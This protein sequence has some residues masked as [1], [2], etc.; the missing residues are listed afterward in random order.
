MKKNSKKRSSS[1]KNIQS[2]QYPRWKRIVFFCVMLCIPAILFILIET[3]LMIFN[4]FPP[5]RLFIPTP[6]ESSE[7]FGINTSVGERYF[8]KRTFSP[9]PRKDLFLRQKP[10]NGY[11]LFVLGGSTAAGFPYGNSV[12]FARILNRRLSDTF[13]DKRIEVVNMAMTAINTYTLLDFMDDL[14]KQKPDALLIYAGH[15]EFYGALGAGSVESAGRHAWIVRLYLKMQRFRTFIM[16]RDAIGRLKKQSGPLTDDSDPMA[17]IM[18]RIVHDKT[19]SRSSRLYETTEQ[20]F[21]MNLHAILKKSNRAGVPV[22]ISELV[23][24]LKDQPPFIAKQDGRPTEAAETFVRARKLETEGRYTEAYNSYEKAKDLDLLRFR[25]PEDF[26]QIIHETASDYQ[27]PVIP[28]KSI[29]EAA[30]PHGLIG[31]SLMCDHLHPNKDGYFLMADAFYNALRQEKLI[32]TDWPADVK[33]SEF[34]MKHWGF[35]PLDSTYAALTV[36]HLKGGWPFRKTGPNRV[37]ELIRART[38]E[39]S[40]VLKIL[41]NGQTT[42]EMGH[43]EL[44]GK[45]ERTGDIERALAEYKALIYTVPNLDLFYEPAVNLLVS[46]NQYQKAFQ[47]L[48][49]GLP[50]NTSFFMMKW[51][52]QLSLVLNHTQAGIGFLER[53]CQINAEDELVLYNL[54]RAYYQTG[55]PNKGESVYSRLKIVKPNSALIGQLNSLRHSGSPSQ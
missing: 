13:P 47:L 3:G 15:N 22:L 34:Y 40:I 42:L 48:Q 35:T 55:Q 5:V 16:L 8:P 7:Y 37:L 18:S 51:A 30:S 20:Q 6:H 28:M 4:L 50:F 11:R 10:E 32:E 24:N 1:E 46:T 39:D 26:N 9:T 38:P 45:F 36:L 54:A 14:L 41:K 21:R 23:S 27:I 2:D 19:I 44:A 12:T 31:S 53:A 49:E 29:F 25:A 33:S 43:I 52:G 17:T